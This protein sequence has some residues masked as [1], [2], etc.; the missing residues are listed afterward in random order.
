VTPIVFA[1]IV[2]AIVYVPML[3]EARRA[4]ANERGQLARGGNEAAGDVYR[5]MQI[6]YPTSFLFM[7]LEGVVRGAPT[8]FR[9]TVVGGAVF[10]AAK[11]LKWWAI[12]TLGPAWTFRVITVPGR[13]LVVAGPYKF[14]RHP[15][16]VGVVGEFVGVA[17]LVGA[18]IAGLLL[19]LGF[20][21]LIL[22]RVR[23]EEDALRATQR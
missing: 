20:F 2:V 5:V 22:K 1:L 23:V 17:L 6:A 9:M 15:N 12:V 3:I 13:P 18:P 4:A 7:I 16:Y 8:S 11:A 19:T 10:A 21:T 14:L